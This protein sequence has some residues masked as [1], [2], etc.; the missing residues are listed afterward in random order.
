VAWLV[1]AWRF[2][3]DV[4]TQRTFLLS[5]LIPLGLGNLLRI[6]EWDAKL[7]LWAGV[8]LPAYLAVMYLPPV[9]YYQGTPL[10]LAYFFALAPLA[11][12]QWGIIA[13]ATAPA[14]GLCWLTD[15]LWSGTGKH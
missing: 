3:D 15:R 13:A 4:T 12:W 14:L 2:G 8:A 10:S 1:S 7:W 6:A 9:G 5:T 11:A